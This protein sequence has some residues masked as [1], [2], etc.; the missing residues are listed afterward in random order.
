MI[1]PSTTRLD[2]PPTHILVLE[3]RHRL[4]YQALQI[5]KEGWPLSGIETGSWMGEYMYVL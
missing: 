3:L 4:E 1:H 5:Q 2:L